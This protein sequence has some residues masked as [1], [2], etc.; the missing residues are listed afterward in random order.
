MVEP[1][2]MAM[3]M[4]KMKTLVCSWVR[5]GRKDRGK[6]VMKGNPKLAHPN[7]NID[8]L[9]CKCS[10]SATYLPTTRITAAL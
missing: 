10:T 7:V 9:R 8:D 4:R 1:V 3:E 6:C 5:V 2:N